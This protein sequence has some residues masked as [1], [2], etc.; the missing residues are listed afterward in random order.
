MIAVAVQF[1]NATL[2]EA[3]GTNELNVTVSFPRVTIT[4]IIGRETEY[5]Q[6]NGNGTT[7]IV[8]SELV[9]KE[10]IIVFTDGRARKTSDYTFTSS[11]GTTT[12]IS[13]IQT[14][15]VIQWLYK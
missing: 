11:T 2:P 4:P 6:A 7:T 10:L 3:V 12:F 8:K 14:A 5:L 15:Q 1:D 9:D 13:V